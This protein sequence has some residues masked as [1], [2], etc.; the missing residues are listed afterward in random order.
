MAARTVERLDL[1]DLERSIAQTLQLGL[2]ALDV[3]ST[4]VLVRA[5]YRAAEAG[6]EVGGDW[7]DAVDLDD[8]RLAVA[9]GDVVGRGLPAAA[10]MG[11]L[12]AALGVA[13]Q[14]AADAADAV[15]ILDH[16]AG[17]VPGAMCAT[18]AFGLIDPAR[19]VMTYVT[20]GHPPPVL[21]GPDGAARFLD[22]AVSWPLGVEPAGTRGPA[23]EV[24]VP[25]GTLVVF[26]TDGLVERRNEPME[27]GLERLRDVVQRTAT[28]P[29]RLIKQAIFTEL[30]DD[31]ATDDIAL[32]AFRIAGATDR[33]FAEVINARPTELAPARH[34]MRAWLADM[35]VDDDAR[36]EILLA[37]GEAVANA[38][39]HGSSDGAQVVRL[40]ACAEDDELIVSISDSGQWQPGL[41]GFFTGRGR[42]HALM[43][44]L[45]D[46]IDV[47]G[48]HN[49]TIVTLRFARH[50]Q[51]A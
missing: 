36:E 38:V 22:A 20:A 12:R 30:V 2:L 27:A 39:E 4:D 37:V 3:R 29:L 5:R 51:F 14:Q 35:G 34:R 10:T 41:E 8:G 32:V 48:D 19:H 26:Y 45:A 50:R 9:V 15:R 47:D 16:Y 33:V 13:A 25:S 46:A 6:M 11:Q 17:H 42:G 28:R 44:A 1:L 7:Y 43:H 21:V 40:E 23:A 31:G 18:V 24:A 49:G